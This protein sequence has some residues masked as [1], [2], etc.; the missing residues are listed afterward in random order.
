MTSLPSEARSI[1][2]KRILGVEKLILIPAT[3]GE[4]YPE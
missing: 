4:Y 3:L 1:D 2:D